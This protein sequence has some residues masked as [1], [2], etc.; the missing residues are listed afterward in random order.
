MGFADFDSV[1]LSCESQ[2]GLLPRRRSDRR[3]NKIRLYNP[4]PALLAGQ[5]VLFEQGYLRFREAAHRVSFQ[6]IIGR[7]FHGDLIGGKRR[8]E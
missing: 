6:Q 2:K 5:Q 8:R 7:V 1:W 3:I 4:V